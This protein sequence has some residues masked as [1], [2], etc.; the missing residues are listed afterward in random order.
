MSAVAIS[1]QKNHKD[2][3]HSH[4]GPGGSTEYKHKTVLW[5]YFP[6]SVLFNKSI[7]F[8]HL[9]FWLLKTVACLLFPVIFAKIKGKKIERQK[10]VLLKLRLCWEQRRYSLR[11]KKYDTRKLRTEPIFLLATFSCTLILFHKTIFHT[12]DISR[13][14]ICVIFCSFSAAFWRG[15]QTES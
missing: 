14:G 8:F 12:S 3:L 15:K 9:C 11:V 5:L 10:D 2:S 4:Q 6:T 7:K 13:L 1:D